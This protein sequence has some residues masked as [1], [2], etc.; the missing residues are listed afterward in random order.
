MLNQPELSNTTIQTVLQTHY[1]LATAAL[2]FLPIG[3]DIAS[4]LYR[5]DAVDGT[6]YFL[7]ARA[8]SSFSAPSVLVPRFLHEQGVAH[9]IA[10][11]PTLSRELW[12]TVGDFS[13]TLYP[14]IDTRTA[15]D[16][17]LSNQHW[18]ALGAALRQIHASQLS[19]ALQQL[20]PQE[21]FI[22]RQRGVLTKLE[23]V[24][25][26]PAN[27]TQRELSAFW[28]EQQTAIHMLIGRADSLGE[29]LRQASSPRVLCHAD[30]HNW[31]VLLDTRQHMWIVD[32]DE[33]VLAPKERDLMFV[34]EGI[35]RDLVKPH[36]TASF[37]QGYGSP[38]VDQQA[39][40]Y[41][42]Y[43]WAVQELAAY[44]E[45]V[46]FLPDHS[47]EARKDAVH[48]FIDVFA[49]GNIAAIAYSSE[50]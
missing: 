49:S 44:A 47:E 5:I 28:H 19:V 10:P 38:A 14:F 18:Q 43:A 26:S 1:G 27:A 30:L 24:I 8:A 37:L 21:T 22:P 20:I 41:Y 48:A 39:L 15:A 7:K 32:W 2:V 33:T 35:G 9:I 46:F 29:A 6:V 16:V 17:G 12:V 34:M 4:F 13:L 31:N 36:E 40:T 42:R 11:V 50:L 3:N 23:S 25:A 45:E